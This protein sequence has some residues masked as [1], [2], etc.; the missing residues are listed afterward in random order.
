MFASSVELI[1]KWLDIKL[2]NSF[3]RH[4]LLGPGRRLTEPWGQCKVGDGVACSHLLLDRKG[5]SVISKWQSWSQKLNSKKER[6]LR[7][8]NLNQPIHQ[9]CRNYDRVYLII[10]SITQIYIIRHMDR[11]HIIYS[12]LTSVLHM[13]WFTIHFWDITLGDLYSFI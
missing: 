9:N 2:E 12:P 1:R 7:N 4:D 6:V 5:Q 10:L 11:F 13:I 8:E 3:S